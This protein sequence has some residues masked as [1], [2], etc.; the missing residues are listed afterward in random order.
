[1]DYFVGLFDES[2][3]HVSKK[4]QMDL[5]VRYWDCVK[6]EVV[7]RYYSSQFLGKASAQDV[8]EKFTKCCPVLD[9]NKLLQ[10][11]S[12]GPNVNL[13]FLNILNEK[14]SDEDLQKLLNIGTCGLHTVHNGLQ[15]WYMWIAHCP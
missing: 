15:H 9:V 3:N 2:Y 12:G 7:T 8:Y 5:H 10:V 14:R 4:S 13:A 11:S 1:M 6:N